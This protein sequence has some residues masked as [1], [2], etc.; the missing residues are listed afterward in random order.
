[1]K[2][3]QQGFVGII[4]I[5]ILAIA[6]GA[7]GTYYLT[8]KQ[9]TDVQINSSIP[10]QP[11]QKENPRAQ[12]ETPVTV[13]V[14]AIVSP[15]VKKDLTD[16]QITSAVTTD[17]SGKNKV[18]GI[19]KG[20]LNSDGYPDAFVWLSLYSTEGEPA[21]ALEIVIQKKDG[22]AESI[23]NLTF[24]YT[25]ATWSG[26]AST[27]LDSVKI[28]SDIIYITSSSFYDNDNYKVANKLPKQTK[29]F[30]LTGSTLVEV[31]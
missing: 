1:M 6:I 15:E 16:Q 20:D 26:G 18:E 5:I 7:G 4:L 31:R 22:S 21:H 14:P 9:K 12:A 13:K 8:K 29:K 30:Q 24:P 19:Y 28:E 3:T 27:K 10:T 17:L 23:K 25:I 2:N 11:E